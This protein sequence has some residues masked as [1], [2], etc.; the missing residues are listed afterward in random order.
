MQLRLLSFAYRYN[1]VSPKADDAVRDI[2]LSRGYYK[3]RVVED[4]EE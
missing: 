1:K 3:K 2:L 4:K